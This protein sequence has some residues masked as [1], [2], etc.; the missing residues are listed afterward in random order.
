MTR[1]QEA[2]YEIVRTTREMILLRDLGPWD[3]YMT[4][5]NAAESV[6]EEVKYYCSTIN[7]RIFYFDSEGELT[8][9][10]LDERGRLAGFAPVSAEDMRH[11]SLGER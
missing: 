6:I 8:E 9:I 2:H 5:T 10:K 1:N 11:Y 3:R 4:I 7:R